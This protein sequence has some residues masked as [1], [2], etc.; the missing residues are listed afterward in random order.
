[1]IK[2]LAAVGVGAGIGHGQGSS[3]VGA[4]HRLIGKAVPRPASPRAGGIP[5]LNHEAPNDTVKDDAI[6][7]V[8]PG[9]KDKIVD[10]KGSFLREQLQNHRA[11]GGLQ[12]G[13]VG[14]G[15]VDH[16][17]GRTVV[18]FHGFAQLLCQE[19]IVRRMRAGQSRNNAGSHPKQHC[20][21]SQLEQVGD[22]RG[23]AHVSCQKAPPLSYQDP[24]GLT[25][26]PTGMGVWPAAPASS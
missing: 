1:M 25:H 13:R 6:V 15:R 7:E 10:G 12:R 16:H 14:L 9:Q 22:A 19:Q 8:I 11:G 4:L 23:H 3:R 24:S 17:G 18:G 26:P 5:A 2:K 20:Q 21:Q